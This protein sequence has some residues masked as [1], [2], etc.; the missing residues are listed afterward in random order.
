MP[1]ETYLR[2]TL[3]TNQCYIHSFLKELPTI[4]FA[5]GYSNQ[6]DEV[7]GILVHLFFLEDDPPEAKRGR[8]KWV[9]FVKQKKAKW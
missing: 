1:C 6:K 4:S 7:K 5:A 9:D 3:T 2:L 8:K